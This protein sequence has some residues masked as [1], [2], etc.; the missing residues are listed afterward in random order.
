MSRQERTRPAWWIRWLLFAAV[1]A[2]TAVT[3]ALSVPKPIVIAIAWTLMSAAIGA[4]LA[5]RADSD[6]PAPSPRTTWSATLAPV[7]VYSESLQM[8]IPSRW[9]G[10]V[11]VRPGAELFDHYGRPIGTV[12]TAAIVGEY[13][14]A[15]GTL[16]RGR[17]PIGPPGFGVEVIG[18]VAKVIGVYTS[19]HMTS[20][21]DDPRIGFQLW[22][23]AD[24]PASTTRHE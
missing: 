11:M 7:D 14:V 9:R 2:A 5:H 4:W 17:S 15:T 8:I 24:H 18:D 6:R 1:I 23:I 16:T 3:Y 10:R 19:I 21:W 20:G 13:L 12:D 22:P